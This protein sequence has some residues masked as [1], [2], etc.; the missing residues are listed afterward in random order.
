MQYRVSLLGYGQGSAY[1]SQTAAFNATNN[2]SNKCQV[3]QIN[4]KP[5]NNPFATCENRDNF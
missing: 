4:N 3:T 5:K 2:Q 1:M